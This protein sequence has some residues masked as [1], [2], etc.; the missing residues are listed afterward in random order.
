MFFICAGLIKIS[1]KINM[2][3]QASQTIKYTNSA[4][5]PRGGFPRM[6]K[7]AGC[8]GFFNKA[9]YP[10]AAIKLVFLS[11]Y[12]YVLQTCFF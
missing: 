1:G 2:R 5:K 8:L 4:F 12:V 6:L 9:F 3:V 11:P 10:A 7:Q